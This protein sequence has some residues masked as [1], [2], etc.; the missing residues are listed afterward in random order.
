MRTP[1]FAR[2]YMHAVSEL[3]Y[4]YYGLASTGM[5]KCRYGGITQIVLQRA[6]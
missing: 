3:G 2:L 1:V 6:T 4:T 5:V